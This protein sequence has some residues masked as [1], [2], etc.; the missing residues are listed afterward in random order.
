MVKIMKIG[1]CIAMQE[2]FS[3]IAS[4]LNFKNNNTTT[5]LDIKEY[6]YKNLEIV[7]I[8]SKIGKSF[9]ANATSILINQYK[10]DVILNIGSCGGVNGANVGD[11]IL[12]NIAGYWDVDVR[13]FGY[14]LGQIPGCDENF[15]STNNKIVWNTL[16]E[17]IQSSK[18]LSGFVISGDSFVSDDKLVEQIKN[19]YPDTLAIDMEGASIAQI[20]NLYN[21]DFILVKKVSDKADK[22]ATNSFKNEII[23]MEEK[24]SLIVKDILDYLNSIG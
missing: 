19:I 22:N 10:C 17:N 23:N 24:T 8:I 15:L 21:K 3:A 14:K 20:C 5:P 11:V 16:I 2:E 7:A 13:G 4:I 9:S 1:I 18:I 6:S 12:S